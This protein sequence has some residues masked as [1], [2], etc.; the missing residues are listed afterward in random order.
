LNG[1]GYWVVL[2][3]GCGCLALAS[4]PEL[5]VTPQEGD[6]RPGRPYRIECEVSWEGEPDEY[7]VAAAEADAIDWGE[8]VVREARSFVRDG[9]NVVAQTVEI[10]PKA[11]GEYKTP[12]L[13]I[14]YLIP[15][16]TSPAEPVA[17]EAAPSDSSVPPALRADPLPL[18]VRPSRTL[19]WLLGGLGASLFFLGAGWWLAQRRR[20]HQPA[21]QPPSPADRVA[22]QTSL[23]Q[24][25]QRRLDGN[26]YEYYQILGRVASEIDPELAASLKSRAEAVG[27]R[28]VRPTDDEMDSDWR[29]LE[30]ALRR[31]EE[32]PE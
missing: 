29:A 12:E 26:H 32:E 22:V 21:P 23:H 13:R 25:R 14:S 24:A 10:T 4:E 6:G 5:K 2:F 28:G 11:T 3:L 30:R 16:T 15:E 19:V 18:F 31:E 8:L 7:A 27:Y 20:S 17:P 9:R 1:F